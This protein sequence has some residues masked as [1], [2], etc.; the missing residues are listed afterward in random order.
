MFN[1]NKIKDGLLVKDFS[2]SIV[3]STSVFISTEAHSLF[4]QSE[5]PTIITSHH[6]EKFPDSAEWCFSTNELVEVLSDSEP[7]KEI[8]LGYI[9]NIDLKCI[10]VE[11][12][13][14]E[15]AIFERYNIQKC[16]V[17]GDFVKVV[18]G[19][20]SGRTGFVDCVSGPDISI[21]ETFSKEVL[22]FYLEIVQY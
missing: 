11:L 20:H 12:K 14:G 10:E 16:I 8:G 5:H 9:R 3:S 19:I 7:F 22:Y 17:V 4:L 15:L 1:G 21:L 6:S 2:A 18:G 13:S